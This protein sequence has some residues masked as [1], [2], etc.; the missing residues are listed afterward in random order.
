MNNPVLKKGNLITVLYE[1][2]AYGKAAL[3]HALLLSHIFQT[4]L[5]IVPLVPYQNELES[6]IKEHTNSFIQKI[7]VKRML[8]HKYN[9]ENSSIL[10]ILAISRT[11]FFSPKK[12]HSWIKNSRIPCLCTS[13]IPPL[14]N[15]YKDILLPLNVRKQDKEKALWAGYFSRFYDACIHILYIN[16]KDA[17]LHKNIFDNILFTQKLYNNLDVK[18]QLHEYNALDENIDDFAFN[19]SSDL[20]AT[21]T[22]IMMTKYYSLIDFL[23]GPQELQILKHLKDLPVLCI[24]ERDD[25]YVLCT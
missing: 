18:Y 17:F 25:L 11:S 19:H 21:L 8:I 5:A 6:F 14:K 15:A 4:K 1:N 20:S 10:M 23:L 24:N 12:A 16:Y 9:E 7:R 3:A 13:N 22:V 2:N